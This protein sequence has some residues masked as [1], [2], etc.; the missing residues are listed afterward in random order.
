[1][2]AFELSSADAVNG[3]PSTSSLADPA[4]SRT[5]PLQ[6]QLPT[7][8]LATIPTN[9]WPVS[10]R[11]PDTRVPPLKPT[12]SGQSRPV[13]IESIVQCISIPGRPIAFVASI[14]V[15]SSASTS[16]AAPLS[17]RSNDGSRPG[18]SNRSVTSSKVV[19]AGTSKA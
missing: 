17:G 4:W 9:R 6:S 10:A 16:G 12:G 3:E 18:S 15:V 11:A 19:S 5:P 14:F 13:S 7:S 2:I 8:T 1:M